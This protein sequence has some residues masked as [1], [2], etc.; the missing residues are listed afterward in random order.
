MVEQ[1]AVLEKKIHELQAQLDFYVGK[2][3]ITKLRMKRERKKYFLK[4]VH[5]KSI[6]SG[7]KSI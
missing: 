5:G 3:G 2:N 4:K 6:R 7:I 1:E